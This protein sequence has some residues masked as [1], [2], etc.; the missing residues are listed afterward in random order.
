[1]NRAIA[2]V[3]STILSTAPFAAHA[4]TEQYSSTAYSVVTKL[5]ER[6]TL[7][8]GAVIEVGQTSYTAIVNDNTGEQASQYCNGDAWLDS[9]GAPTHMVAHCTIFYD[10]GDLAWV[11]YTGTTNDAPLTWT[12]LGGTGKYAGAT[13]TGTSKRVSMRGDGYS[14][15]YKA[16]GTI[17]TK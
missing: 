17:T 14:G 11:S 2:F 3:L 7:P 5:G 1:M 8:N 9:A 15:T 4:A 13:G 16:T 10:N 12:V 6:E